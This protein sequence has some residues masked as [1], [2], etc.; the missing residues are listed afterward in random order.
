ME[1][2]YHKTILQR[3]KKIFRAIF[4]ALYEFV[5]GARGRRGKVALIYHVTGPYLSRGARALSEA[6]YGL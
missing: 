4:T 3:R 6:S 1:K 2:G 5:V